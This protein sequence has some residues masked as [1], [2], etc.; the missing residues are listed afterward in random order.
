MSTDLDSWDAVNQ[1]VAENGGVE[2]L[3]MMIAQGT[4]AGK[5]KSVVEFY[6]RHYD[7]GVAASEREAQ[8]RRALELAE[9]SAVA[10]ER[11][12]NAS[13]RSADATERAADAAGKSARFAMWAAVISLVAIVVTLAVDFFRVTL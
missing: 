2:P 3:R 4:L 6:L 5:R 13:K 10:S 1:Y 11:S 7:A 9:R 8:A 12:A